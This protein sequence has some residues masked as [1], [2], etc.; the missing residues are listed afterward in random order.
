MP[1][2]K[3]GLPQP[4]TQGVQGAGY[5]CP[6]P[7]QEQ[8][9]PAILQGKDLIATAQT[10]TGKTAAFV[11]PILERLLRTERRSSGPQC[12]VLTP[13][14]ELALQVEE[15]VRT[16]GRFAN[17]RSVALYGGVALGPQISAL[18]SHPQV[19]VATPGRL[20]DH[21]GRRNVHF[22][23]LSVLVL[24]EADRMLDMGFLP[25]IRRILHELPSERQNLLFSATMSH[26]VEGLA[27]RLMK[28]PVRISIGVQA[29]P[30][31]GVS[32]VLY[33]V[34]GHLKTQLLARLLKTTPHTSVLV[35]TRTKRGAERVS[36]SLTNQGFPA[37]A[38]HGD[39]SQS[40][41]ERALQS[42]RTGKHRI[43]VATDVAARGL[44]IRGISHVVNYDVPE[45]YDAYVHR[46]G[47]TARA[48]ALGKAFTLVAYH[49]EEYIV[50]IERR[51]KRSLPR[52]SVT[53][54]EYSAP[55]PPRHSRPRSGGARTKGRGRN[56]RREWARSG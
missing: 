28:N 20:L 41:R 15:S 17:V 1:F 35:F 46:I 25:D 3:L 43:L 24:D 18:R 2:A 51:L 33:P 49:E 42:F 11:L 13:T 54:F 23:D 26:G 48:N 8:A 47:R 38:L 56:G 7:I 5:K 29:T 45:T 10:G 50:E 32:Q 6:T 16:Y 14:R 12:L 21:L 40:Q 27:R 44:D 30:V 55:V 37:A 36:R 52:E 39:K 22:K 34:A 4:I 9:I 31:E 53:D 19:V